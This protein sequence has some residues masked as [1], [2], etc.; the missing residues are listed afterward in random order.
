MRRGSCGLT[1]IALVL[2]TAA[3]G[4]SDGA[5]R[6]QP[7]PG[8][9]WQWQLSDLPVD[10]TVDAEVYD[11]DLFETTAEQ[12]AE[13]QGSGRRVICYVSMGSWEEPRPD[14]DAFPDRVLGEVYEGYPDERWLDIRRLDL[15]GPIL[16]ARFD[17][18]DRKGFDALEPDNID[19]Y[20]NDT[21]FD[22]SPGDQLRFNRWLAAE[23]HERGLAI[24][25]K[26]DPDQAEALVDTFDFA[27]TED[28][29]V[30]DWCEDVEVFI[31][32]GKGVLQAEYTD[33]DVDFDEVCADARESEFSPILKERELT[34][35][36]ETC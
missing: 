11:V 35:F 12:V 5:E 27:L 28:C 36:R 26:N 8:V 4:A 21:G 16:E 22:L 18:C 14:A 10:G 9:D 32:Q 29:A 1:V 20:Q 19:G 17:R 24:A 30:D 34:A 31:E 15:L 7:E 23:A 25:L 2:A 6:W 33:T 13:L 3:C